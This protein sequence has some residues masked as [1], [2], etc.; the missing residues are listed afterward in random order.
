MQE[1]AR[2]GAASSAATVKEPH[3]VEVGA[4][5][6]PQPCAVSTG[7]SQ[8][9]SPPSQR[10][11]D[12][13]APIAVA[14]VAPLDPSTMVADQIHISD[15]S[16]TV[17]EDQF[18]DQ[19]EA[20]INCM[21]L[22]LVLDVYW[23]RQNWDITKSN[24]RKQP[25]TPL[26]HGFVV[27]LLKS[28]EFSLHNAPVRGDRHNCATGTIITFYGQYQYQVVQS[29]PRPPVGSLAAALVVDPYSVLAAV[30]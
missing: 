10:W 4:V 16:L 7:T 14:A 19:V 12:S 25:D 9:Q 26:R 29:P 22:Q 17:S 24:L 21:D 1:G 15:M 23:T 2:T 18:W 28:V 20:L 8:N 5:P 6:N 30:C 27:F 11:V 3:R 13:K